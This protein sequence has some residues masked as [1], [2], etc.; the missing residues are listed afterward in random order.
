MILFLCSTALSLA[1]QELTLEQAQ[2]R[3]LAQHGNVR[4]AALAVEQASHG[5]DA[6]R[7]RRLPRLDVS[8]GYT[9][10]SETASID[11]AIPGLPARFHPLRTRRTHKP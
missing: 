9:H 5:I 7:A 11:L 8:A 6:A 4:I 2:Q 10:I 1:Q 3:A